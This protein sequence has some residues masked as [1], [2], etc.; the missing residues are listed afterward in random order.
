MLMEPKPLSLAYKDLIKA[1]H[2]S[3][4]TATSVTPENVYQEGDRD[5]RGMF[6]AMTSDL[7]S[8]GSRINGME[9]LS[10]LLKKAKE[11]AACILF[12][13]HYSNMDLPGVHYLLRRSGPEGV[14]IADAIV[15]IAGRK[16]N[17]ENPAVAAFASAFTRIVLC[18]SRYHYTVDGANNERLR[19]ININRAAMKKL[20][21][22]KKQG[23]I[24]LVFPAGTRFRPWDPSSKRGVREIDSYIKSFDYFC[25]VAVNGL[26][27]DV[28]DGDMLED[29]VMNDVLHYTA[30]PVLSCSDFRAS[31]KKKAL[32][33]GAEDVKQAIVDDLMRVL[34][35][36]HEKAEEPRRRLLS[37]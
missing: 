37:T 24:I 27:L 12:V 35:Q 29:C 5:I 2:A 3:S 6:D 31:A 10:L 25:P 19:V 22:V 7:L 21:E 8:P 34:D 18:P 15:A 32:E 14:E 28:R 36:I 16:L 30:G 23:K 33:S 26:V 17:E 20:N 11:G 9:N 1:I 4:K 13:E